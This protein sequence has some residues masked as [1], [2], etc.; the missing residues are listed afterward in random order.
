MAFRVAVE[1][2]P[3]VRALRDHLGSVPPWVRGV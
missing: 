1:S 3:G 2:V